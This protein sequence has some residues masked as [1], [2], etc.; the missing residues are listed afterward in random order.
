MFGHRHKALHQM[1]I[2]LLRPWIEYQLRN[3]SSSTLTRNQCINR[4][5]NQLKWGDFKHAL[6]LDISNFF[7]S[8]NT[9]ALKAALPLPDVV[10]ANIV[11]CTQA[12]IH[13]SNSLSRRI[14]SE[15]RRGVPQGSALSALLTQF[16]IISVLETCDDLGPFEFYADNIAILG[17]R[18][19]DLCRG[20]TSLL[21]AFERH[22][23]GGFRLE[24]KGSVA[25]LC[26]GFDFLGCNIRQTKSGYVT[27]APSHR[28][29]LRLID[30]LWTIKKKT[31]GPT[32]DMLDKEAVDAVGSYRRNF[33]PM[34]DLSPSLYGFIE[35]LA[36]TRAKGS[37]GAWRQ[38]VRIENGLRR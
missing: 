16:V 10:F 36:Y 34:S 1:L 17:L 11:T 19:E 9:A 2:W 25:R 29:H 23:F 38:F 22:P 21:A 15:S 20:H 28:N 8:I 30:R 3:S 5:S 32:S 18:K 7:G 35:Y 26:D 27:V 14:S 33:P 4:F 24:I 13:P 31:Y 37:Q 12:N 6:Q